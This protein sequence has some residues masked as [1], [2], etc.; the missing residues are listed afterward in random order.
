MPAPDLKSMGPT[1]SNYPQGYKWPW[2]VLVRGCVHSAKGEE[3][4]FTIGGYG[5]LTI[6][7]NG[8]I[9]ELNEVYAKDKGYPSRLEGGW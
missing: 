2:E 9:F 7:E 3:V 8:Y 5:V 1:L 6:L 4:E